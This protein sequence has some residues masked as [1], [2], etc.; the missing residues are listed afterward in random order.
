MMGYYGRGYGY[1]YGNMMDGTWFG[2]LLF[3]FFLALVL[4]GI[5]LLVIWAVRAAGGGHTVNGGATPPS[6]AV[7]HDEAV[8]IAKRRLAG[9]EITK[10]QYDEIMRTLGG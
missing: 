5:V 3:L 4:V 10:E 1:G 9:G 7:G 2:G 6:G 8:A